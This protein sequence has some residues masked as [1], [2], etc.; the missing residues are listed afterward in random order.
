MR[1]R[2]L[3]AAAAVGLV[4]MS[5]LSPRLAAADPGSTLVE[6]GLPT[7]GCTYNSNPPSATGNSV[8]T[9][10]C[11]ASGNLKVTG[12]S[13]GGSSAAGYYQPSPTPFPTSTIAPPLLD[14]YGEM[15]IA[16]GPHATAFNVT[17]VSGCS[18]GAGGGASAY[19]NTS[20]SPAPASTYLPFAVDAYGRMILSSQSMTQ[21]A[22]GWFNPNPVP[23]SA[24]Q[25]APA[26][27]DQY[28]NL[29]VSVVATMAPGPATINDASGQVKTAATSQPVFNANPART[30][31]T[32]CVPP[33]Q[34]Y[35]LWINDAAMGTSTVFAP[36]NYT[37]I[38]ILP[39]QCYTPDGHVSQ[40]EV[41]I[42]STG[43]PY[44]T[45]REVQ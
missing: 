10:R 2:F 18:G 17:C 7:S 39:G 4:V 44:F 22:P 36:T 11:D 14:A 27:L 28:G 34:I 16:P 12:I 45:A 19:Y 9:F 41:D 6:P 20:P 32:I 43:T 30:S 25:Q 1:A 15:M 24:F 29:Q 8:M 42:N 33:T 3:A 26:N 5:A 37:S 23:L 31:Y 21:T 13:G 35:P 38:E 40:G